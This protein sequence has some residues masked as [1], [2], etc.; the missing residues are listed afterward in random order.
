MQ[1]FVDFDFTLCMVLA[2]AQLGWRTCI[3]KL[4]IKNYKGANFMVIGKLF[5][6]QQA[7]H[8]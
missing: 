8:C 3:A 1:I 7:L 2:A 6:Q 5:N 4:I